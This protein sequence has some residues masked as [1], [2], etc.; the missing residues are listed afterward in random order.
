MAFTHLQVKSG[1]SLM[2]STIKIEEL[3]EEAGRLGY[4]ALA[5]TDHEVMH[6]SV[7][8]YQACL[9]AGIKP[10][11]GLELSV[12]YEHERFPCLFIAEN[13]EGY[14]NLMKISS[15]IQTQ[16][17]TPELAQL[18]KYSQGLIVIVKTS[19]T[20]WAETFVQ[21]REMQVSTHLAEWREVFGNEDVFL[22]IQDVDLHEERQIHRP[23]KEWSI[24]EEVP[25]VTLGDVKYLHK[26]DAEA[27]ECLQAIESGSRVS[28]GTPAKGHE[29]LKSVDEMERY[30][31]DWWPEALQATED[32]QKRCEVTIDL[33]QQL[34][35]AYPTPEGKAADEY[36]E[37]LCVRALDDYSGQNKKLAH[38]RLK[39]ELSVIQSMSFSDYFLIVWDFIAY[40]RKEGIHVGPGRGSAAGS[41]V[42]YLLEITQVDPLEYD[43]LFE[44]FLNPERVSM[45]DIDID[46]P[47]HRRDE[48]IRYVADKYG[49]H[50]VAQI[51]TFGTFG[52]RSVL[53][54]L[55][56]AMSIDDQD[57]AYILKQI[58][59]NSNLSLVEIVKDSDSLKEYIKKDEALKRLFRVA[60]K[61]EGLPRHVSTHAAGVIISEKPL[62]H[63]TALMKG[64]GNAYLTQSAMNELESV[65]LLKVDFLGLR[66]LTLLERLEQKLQRYEDSSFH[67]DDIPLH[68]DQTFEL[69]KEGRTNGVFQL[70]S[71]GMKQ[72]L[73]RLA[74][75]HFE[76]VVA[77]NALYRP[78]PMEYIQTYVNRK[79]ER[80]KVEYPH[81]DI[82]TVLEPTF[83][84]L[85]YQE[86]I[87]QVAQKVAGYS[88]GQADILRRAVSKKQS[89]T[90]EQQRN[91]FIKGSVSKGYTEQVAKQLFEWIVKFSNYGFNRSHAVAYSVISFKLAYIK[92]HYPTYFIAELMNANLGDQE[93]VSMYIREA[94]EAGILVSPPS[95]NKSGLVTKDENGGIRLGLVAIKGIGFQA[96]EEILQERRNARFRGLN[97]FCLRITSQSIS[98][99]VIESLI[100]AGAFDE[101]DT[102]RARLLAS[103]DQALEQGELFKEFQDQPEL[104][105]EDFG[106]GEAIDI[107]PFP[108]LKKLAMEKDV[109]GS[110]LSDHPLQEF[111]TSLEQGGFLPI[112]KSIEKLNQKVKIAAVIESIKEIR[113]KRGESMAFVNLN[114]ENGEVDAVIFPDVYREV[115]SWMNEQILV[116]IQGK[117]EERRGS[118]QLIIQSIQRFEERDSTSSNQRLFVKVQAD[119]ETESVDHLRKLARYFPGN[120]PIVIFRAEDRKTYQLEDGVTVSDDLMKKMHQFFAEDSVV[121]R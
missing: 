93:K 118:A 114:D 108:P 36:L 27:F 5:L 58:P 15:W 44:R 81:P 17:V 10:I 116:M 75:S 34:I 48:V 23:M 82:S 98:R 4:G 103:V 25:V 3:A 83:G 107:E 76:D 20:I 60:A 61:L 112:R 110:Y 43:L 91:A 35:P 51:C 66:N 85:V 117:V 53:R 119:Q 64:Q 39:H 74:P 19:Q 101:F 87:M 72:V 54:D 70:E 78:G 38:D 69:L 63:Y 7:S 40:A 49:R 8:F 30:F 115:R 113:T 67:I 21:G 109:L 56:K 100:I 90:L 111:R 79:H 97:D 95:V 92:A 104:F 45:P 86:Q 102:N 37:E 88:L 41:F 105:S 96:A 65:G 59:K 52:S 80:E 1:Y 16:G 9:K 94:R 31:I 28:A 13:N 55:F 14:R 12:Q 120:T 2:Q 57:A 89:D 22:G 24:K 71:Q 99:N 26:E 33:E 11:I 73:R 29:Y 47:D 32:I 68:D 77:V 42:A 18:T 46:F 62:I 50:H 121:L 106:M 84:V 6:G